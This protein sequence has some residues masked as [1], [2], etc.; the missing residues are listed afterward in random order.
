MRPVLQQ[1]LFTKKIQQRLQ[2]LPFLLHTAFIDTKTH[3]GQP[4]GQHHRQYDHHKQQLYQ[5]EPAN[6]RKPLL[7]NPVANVCV[8]SFATGLAI[9]T[10]RT[11]HGPHAPCRV[12]P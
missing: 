1:G 5:R 11:G 4:A 10:K 6:P 8:H 9:G 7:L 12:D 2:A 3:Q